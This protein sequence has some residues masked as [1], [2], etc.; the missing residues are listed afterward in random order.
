MQKRIRNRYGKIG[1]IINEKFNTMMINNKG[2]KVICEINNIICG[3]GSIDK[4]KNILELE[5]ISCFKFAPLNSCDTERSFSRY[6][7][8][9]AEREAFK[10]DNFKMNLITNY[11]NLL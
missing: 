3:D 8:L 7:S 9:L 10:F 1:T 5:D 2:F 11:N 4:V 6:K